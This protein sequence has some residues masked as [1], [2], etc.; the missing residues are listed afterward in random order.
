V[1]LFQ[2]LELVLTILDCVMTRYGAGR[3]TSALSA[4]ELNTT[5]LLAFIARI[6]YQLVVGSTK[7][8]ICMSFLRVFQDR[9]GRYWMFSLITF[10]GVFTTA[11]V[12]AS[13]FQCRPIQDAW[14]NSARPYETGASNS[15]INI[16]YSVW[17]S[18]ICNI[19]TDVLLLLFVVPRICEWTK[20]N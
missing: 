19:V 9:K 18:G 13:I 14:A 16:L 12:F 3:H 20:Q 1:S 7:I 4:D 8:A 5:L 17:A 11:L 15:C 2:T 6:V 10:A